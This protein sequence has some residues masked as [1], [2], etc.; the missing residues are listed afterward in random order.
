MIVVSYI[1]RGLGSRAKKKEIRELVL[2]LGTG[3]CFFFLDMADVC[4]LHETK[5]ERVDNK[6]CKRLWG[7]GNMGWVSKSSEGNSG[8][9]LTLWN[10]YKFRVVSS[11]DGVGILVVNGIW[12]E[13]GKNCTIRWVVW[14]MLQ[15]LSSQYQG[16][17]FGIIWDF[18]SI[19]EPHERVGGSSNNDERDMAKFN[20]FIEG[21]GLS[22]YTWYRPDGTCKSKL[23]RML[24]NEEWQRKWPN[25]KLIGGGRT[26]SD[27]CLIFFENIS[28]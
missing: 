3:V 16:D 8:G 17:Y 9:L 2:K 12:V 25:F 28:F 19:R 26:L 15:N 24:I 23:D 27:H 1:I 22:E 21:S 7:K 13:D 11:W 10:A 14:D 6:L 18:N 5:M 4:C 20:D